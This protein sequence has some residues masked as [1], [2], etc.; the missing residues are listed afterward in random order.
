MH[1]EEIRKHQL[2]SGALRGEGCAERSELAIP[3]KPRRALRSAARR[4]REQLE[5]ARLTERDHAAP[6]REVVVRAARRL[7]RGDGRDGRHLLEMLARDV[8][9]ADAQR[10]ALGS[11]RAHARDHGSKVTG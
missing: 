8:R 2:G 7:H 5:A 10:Q 4:M 11:R 9:D 1:R 3:R 6:H